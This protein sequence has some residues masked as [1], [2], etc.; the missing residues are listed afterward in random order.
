MR[1]AGEVIGAAVC[2]RPLIFAHC[3]S[4]ACA[5]LPDFAKRVSDRWMSM[6]LDTDRCVV[7]QALA[8]VFLDISYQNW[9]QDGKAVWPGLSGPV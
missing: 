9:L 7:S 5:H 8:T 6:Q 1:L 4:Q 2:C 3:L